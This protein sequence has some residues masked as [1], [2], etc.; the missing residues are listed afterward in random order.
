MKITLDKITMDVD[1]T[2]DRL[3]TAGGLLA[4]GGVALRLM[5]NSHLGLM[6]DVHDLHQ[7]ADLVDASSLATEDLDAIIAHL[8][9]S[10]TG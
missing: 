8:D 6:D 5:T 1:P 3:F 7:L 2:R 10:R 4:V 9:P